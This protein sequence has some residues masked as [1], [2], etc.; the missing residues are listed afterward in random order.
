MKKI[1]TLIALLACCLPGLANA[2]VISVSYVVSD[3]DSWWG[4]GSFTGEDTNY[5][6]VLEF[7]ELLTFDGS[8][9]TES[10]TVDLTTLVDI[11]D[12]DISTNTWL[13][14]AVSWIGYD[15][16]AWFTWNSQVNSVNLT[17]ATVT[18]T[19]DVPEPSSLAIFG[20]GLLSFGAW[21]RRYS[22][23]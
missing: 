11:G 4:S 12:Y 17:W 20:M 9:N 7:S 21:R 6:G 10:E 5:D 2:G 13:S 23:K 3:S 15:N 19:T 16:N 14:D 22:K 8:N 1:I 18:T